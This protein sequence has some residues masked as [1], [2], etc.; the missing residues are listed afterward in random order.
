MSVHPAAFSINLRELQPGLRGLPCRM[1]GCERYLPY[2]SC[3][4]IIGDQCLAACL[5]IVAY[6]CFNGCLIPYHPSWS[7]AKVS[8]GSDKY[9][10]CSSFSATVLVSGHLKGW[11]LLTGL[12]WDLS[13]D[14]LVFLQGTHQPSMAPDFPSASICH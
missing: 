7:Q 10:H 13:G 3:S 11:F 4:L 14:C 12:P 5:L 8:T 2:C 6:Q 9:F 1:I